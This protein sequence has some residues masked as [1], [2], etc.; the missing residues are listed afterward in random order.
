MGKSWQTENGKGMKSVAE[1]KNSK[2][3]GPD[4]GI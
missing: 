4:F 2:D 3:V 1:R